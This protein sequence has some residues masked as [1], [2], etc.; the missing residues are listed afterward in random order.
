VEVEIFVSPSSKKV[1]DRL[2]KS[3]PYAAGM[4]RLHS[5]QKPVDRAIYELFPKSAIN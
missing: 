3:K 5:Y 4:A 1:I 2:A